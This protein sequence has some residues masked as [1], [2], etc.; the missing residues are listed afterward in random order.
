MDAKSAMALSARCANMS[1]VPCAMCRYAPP[2]KTGSVLCA[3]SQQMVCAELHG[4]HGLGQKMQVRAVG[5][6][7]EQ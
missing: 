6:I 3:E 5:I 7:D 2:V 4:V 1:G